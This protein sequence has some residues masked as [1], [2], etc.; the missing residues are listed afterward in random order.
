[1]PD[2]IDIKG[3]HTGSNLGV[4]AVGSG[5]A[6]LAQGTDGVA[7]GAVASG[8]GGAEE[9]EA[10]LAE[11][12]SEVEGA[13][14][15]AEHG[16]GAVGGVDQAFEAAFVAEEEFAR[17][18][19]GPG[20]DVEDEAEAF[21]EP[22]TAADFNVALNGPL[23]GGPT[24]EGGGENERFNGE[25]AFGQAAGLG[26]MGGGRGAEGGGEFKVAVDDVGREGGAGIGVE[27]GGVGFAE[28]AGGEAPEALRTTAP[29]QGAAFEE[30]LEV[31]GGIGA[32]AVEPAEGKE[33]AEGGAAVEGEEMIGEA[34]TG[35]EGH[36]AGMKDPG[37]FGAG[38]AVAECGNGR[39]GMEN[40]SHGAEAHHKQLRQREGT[41]W[42]Y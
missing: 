8:V 3:E 37:E 5:G 38:K 26:Q 30:A 14:I 7:V 13:A 11:E 12:G 36:P 21:F 35:D 4:A 20:H 19:G 34:E 41:P 27:Q 9:G 23:F 25:G 6:G 40:V 32:K 2:G 22:E 16:C 18:Q 31:D 10:G 28:E 24:G 42:I 15:E 33:G 17:G 29:S 1:M 39:D